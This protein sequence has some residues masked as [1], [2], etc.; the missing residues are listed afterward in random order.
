MSLLCSSLFII[1]CLERSGRLT[2]ESVRKV[3]IQGDSFGDFLTN[4]RVKYRCSTVS[5]TEA[6]IKRWVELD[7]KFRD[8]YEL[9]DR[10]ICYSSS[11]VCFQSSVYLLCVKVC[12]FDVNESEMSL[13]F[14]Q[15]SGVIYESSCRFLMTLNSW[16]NSLCFIVVD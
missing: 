16:L 5:K 8:Y 13:I 9:I 12:S 10:C 7:R 1:S 11:S 14:N 2:I 3:R 15:I 4:S 6:K